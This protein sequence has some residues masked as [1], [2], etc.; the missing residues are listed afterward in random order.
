MSKLRNLKFIIITVSIIT[1][2]FLLNSCYAVDLNLSTDLT[3]NMST[4]NT[5]TTTGTNTNSSQ[6]STN[7]S[8]NTASDTNSSNTSNTDKRVIP[9]MENHMV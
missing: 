5:D 1:F 3:S 7:T 2:I 4:T 8:E 6:D 9:Y